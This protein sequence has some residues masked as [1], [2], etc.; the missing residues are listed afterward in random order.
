MDFR[1]YITIFARFL[2][3]FIHTMSVLEDDDQTMLSQIDAAL[4]VR[5]VELRGE[6][7]QQTQSRI[8]QLT[9]HNRAA[10]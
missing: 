1:F 2:S 6:C 8:D 5:S 7:I 3:S 4:N 10:A 9:S